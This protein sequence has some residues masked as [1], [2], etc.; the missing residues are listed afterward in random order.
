MNGETYLEKYNIMY[1][2]FVKNYIGDTIFQNNYFE[3]PNSSLLK[4]KFKSIEEEKEIWAKYKRSYSDYYRQILFDHYQ[5]YALYISVFSINK[6]S[7]LCSDFNEYISFN[8]ETLYKTIL[9]YDINS[10]ASFTTYYLNESRFLIGKYMRDNYMQTL[11]NRGTYERY[12]T[13]LRFV[14]YYGDQDVYKMSSQ[15]FMHKYHMR[16]STFVSLYNLSVQSLDALMEKFS[17]DVPIDKMNENF[18]YGSC[19]EEEI[20]NKLL[21]N[22]VVNYVKS[23]T[24]ARDFAIWHE[25]YF[26]GNNVTYDLIGNRFNLTRERVRQVLKK[27]N[28]KVKKK[29]KYEGLAS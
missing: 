18:I 10:N 15:E 24:C 17:G 23:N 16:K 13:V 2:K 21:K 3:N 11:T 14:E 27:V 6:Y 5:L 20:C 12:K 26:G 25:Y 9:R 22:K 4:P 7:Y 28:E 29:L 1:D 8:L 19:I